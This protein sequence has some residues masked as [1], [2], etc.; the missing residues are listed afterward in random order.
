MERRDTLHFNQKMKRNRISSLLWI[1]LLNT[2]RQ[3]KYQ[4]HL[5]ALPAYRPQE[6]QPS[7]CSIFFDQIK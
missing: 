6:I 4:A 7:N 1:K 5:E 3:P 2:H